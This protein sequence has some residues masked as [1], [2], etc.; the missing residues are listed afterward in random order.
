[1]GEGS[2][3][4]WDGLGTQS[5]SDGSFTIA[6]VPPGE[7]I[8]LVIELGPWRRVV[9]V[10]VPPCTVTTLSPE[11]TR[12]PR[13]LQEGNEMD[14]IPRIAVAT[15]A[16]DPIECV[17]RKLGVE[18]SQFSNAGGDGR[19]QFYVDN[20]A[21]FDDRTP[22][23]RQLTASPDELRRYDAVLYPCR[24]A[25]HTEPAEDQ[26][27]LL[28]LSTDSSSYLR[29]HGRILLSHHS[30]A[31]LQDMAPWNALPWLSDADTG[32]TLVA[33][34]GTSFRRGQTVAEWLALPAVDALWAADPPR[35]SL[36]GAYLQV[37][38]PLGDASFEPWLTTYQDS[39][40]PATLLWMFNATRLSP[41]DYNPVGGR[42]VFSSFHVP[43]PE[44]PGGT[45]AGAVFPEECD[46]TFTT[47]DKLLAYVLFELMRCFPPTLSSD[48]CKGFC[49]PLTCADQ[50]IRCGPAG[51]GCGDPIDCGPC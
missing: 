24:G 33:E 21:V 39:P 37:S 36:S 20:G 12:L 23:Y 50:A 5:A 47:Q 15:G 51:N 41:T 16:D 14:N 2:W 28:E 8:P 11:Q 43:T 3:F 7:A 34:V 45:A 17:L 18:D 26:A 22:N 44:I 6:N 32:S 42:V 1:V 29:Y 31:W 27:R 48:V 49:E 25:A 30:A 35:V 13:R 40:S 9:R 4:C 10:D 46:D 19:I 38:N